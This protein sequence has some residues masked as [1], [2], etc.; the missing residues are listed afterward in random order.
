[1][2]LISTEA[3]AG[4]ARFAP[5]RHDLVRLLPIRACI[6][7]VALEVWGLGI[8]NLFIYPS[9]YLY[10]GLGCGVCG[11]ESRDWGQGLRVSGAGNDLAGLLSFGAS[12]FTGWGRFAFQVGIRFWRLGFRNWG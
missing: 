1:M 6:E 3:L 10:K 12:V 7:R 9:M 11:Y 8:R 4:V 5:P 2:H